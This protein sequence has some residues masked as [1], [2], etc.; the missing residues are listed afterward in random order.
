MMA[1]PGA[2][3][4]VRFGRDEPA[5]PQRLRDLP[6]PPDAVWVRGTL[7]DASTKA[8]AIVGTREPTAYGQRVARELAA[9]CARAGVVVVSGL[10]RGVDAAAHHG[11]L[12][13]G[14]C[15]VGVVGGGPDVPYPR[16][17]RGLQEAVAMSGG[18]LSEWAPGTEARPWAFPRRNAFIAALADVVIVVEAGHKSGA[19]GTVEH[20]D[21]IGRT[22]AAV[23]GPIDSPQSAGT[24]RLLRDGAQ[25][26]ASLDDALALLGATPRP[27]PDQVPAGL[28]ADAAACWRALGQRACDVEGLVQAT[29][30]EW[31]AAVTAVTLLEVRGL[32]VAD[33]TGAYR[34]RL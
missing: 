14:G 33:L 29:G 6:E 18:V 26:V 24:N 28:P 4:V 10:A 32:A 30:L 19:H 8:V 13:A 21:R 27:D 12:D 5:Y 2:P 17:H 7:P 20:A 25:V 23:P 11:A 9:A 22:F 3:A 34:R 15:T 1:Q 31:R 16:G